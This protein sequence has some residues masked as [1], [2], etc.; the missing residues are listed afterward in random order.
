MG[1]GHSTHQGAAKG[2]G[3]R[4]E[5][6]AKL[7]LV[8][9]KGDL[10]CGLPYLKVHWVVISRILSALNKILASHNYTYPTYNPTYTYP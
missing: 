7:R 3:I 1:G 9:H 6:E 4:K 8:K 2:E 10:D 5:P